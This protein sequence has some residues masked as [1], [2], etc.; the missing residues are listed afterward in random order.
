MFSITHTFFFGRGIGWVRGE[1]E[2]LQAKRRRGCRWGTEI[3]RFSRL[4]SL[5]PWNVRRGALFLIARESH[6][7]D[8]DSHVVQSIAQSRSLVFV[9]LLNCTGSPVGTRDG[10]LGH[11]LC[12]RFSHVD[13]CRTYFHGGDANGSSSLVD[14]PR[15]ILKAYRMV[16][17]ITKVLKPNAEIAIAINIAVL[18]GHGLKM[19]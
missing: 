5:N 4:L 15:L 9:Q 16:L 1:A 17:V 14:F 2:S 12:L 13:L 8:W 18:D 6:G 10:C 3:Q 7:K 19:T 11:P